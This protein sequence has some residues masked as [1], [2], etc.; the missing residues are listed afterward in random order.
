VKYSLCPRDYI[1]GGLVKLTQKETAY[2]LIRNKVA[3]GEYL[4][5]ERIY[6]AALAQEIG[7]SL[8]PIREAISRLQSEGIIVHRPH[9]GIFVKE[10]ERR[11]LVDMIEFRTT[12]ECAA[13]AAAARRITARRREELDKAWDALCRAIEPFNIP[14]G[15]A[16]PDLTQRLQQW[17]LADLAFHMLILRIAGNRQAIRA[18]EE[19]HIML[20]MFGRRADTPDDW[21]RPAAYAAKNLKFHKDIYDAVCRNDAKLARRAMRIHLRQAGR[22][23]LARFDWLQQHQDDR[24]ARADDLP[25]SMR[26]RESICKIQSGNANLACNSDGEWE[27]GVKSS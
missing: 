12:L 3:K 25:D 15:T 21:V 24:E 8:I 17:Y 4:A 1:L 14:P 7:A 5:G 27:T 9:R 6:P 16:I 2:R 10:M 26:M 23:L 11:D 13:A 18:A 19:A 20:R 22:S